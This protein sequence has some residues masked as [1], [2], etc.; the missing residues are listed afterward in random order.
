MMYRVACVIATGAHITHHTL[1]ITHH[2]LH[3]TR[4]TAECNDVV[5]IR[6]TQCKY[7]QPTARHQQHIYV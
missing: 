7:Q 1:H 5:I 6:S 3:I 4:Y 2:T